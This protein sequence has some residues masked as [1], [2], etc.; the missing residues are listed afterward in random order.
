MSHSRYNMSPNT[1]QFCNHKNYNKL[2][3]HDPL[4]KLKI[5]FWF[6]TMKISFHEDLCI[7][8]ASQPSNIHISEET[9]V[10]Y[11]CLCNNRVPLPVWFIRD[12]VIGIWVPSTEPA[13][14]GTP[15]FSFK[16]CYYIPPLNLKHQFMLAHYGFPLAL[17]SSYHGF[18][19][20]F[21]SIVTR[22]P[23]MEPDVQWYQLQYNSL[24][25]FF[26]NNTHCTSCYS[27][28]MGYCT[29]L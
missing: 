6:A 24:S 3:A 20:Y 18:C 12:D 1:K 16:A 27:K 11:N 25:S 13:H 10:V 22:L 15:H 23:Q 4:N 9:I 2:E 8:H 17:P 14:C 19:L 7:V 29:I 26:H 28:E 21:L 5:L